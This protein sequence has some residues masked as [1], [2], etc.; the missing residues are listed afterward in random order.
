MQVRVLPPSFRLDSVWYRDWIF[1]DISIC[2]S[3]YINRFDSYQVYCGMYGTTK[4]VLRLFCDVIFW[5]LNDWHSTFFFSL[6]SWE[7]TYWNLSVCG[8]ID[9]DN[10]KTQEAF[11]CVECGHE[12]NADFNAAINIKNRVSVTVLQRLLKQV[13]NSTFKPKPLKRAKVKEVLLSCRNNI[14]NDIE[15]SNLLTSVNI[16]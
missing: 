11:K 15:K 5:W 8:C 3:A 6:K 2:N 16:C 13:D 14:V 7:N 4:I 1:S 9:D 10:R 12:S